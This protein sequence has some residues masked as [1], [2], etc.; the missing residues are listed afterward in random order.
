MKDKGDG[1]LWR[2]ARLRWLNSR[3]GVDSLPVT[4]FTKMKVH[5]KTIVASE[6]TV[7]LDNNGMLQS[8]SLNKKEV[9]EKPVWIEVET[10]NGT[11]TFNKGK[12]QLK[13]MADGLVERT[14]NKR[15]RD[16]STSAASPSIWNTE[17]LC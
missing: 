17:K 11:V 2:M 3:I 15:Q 6:K 13:K 9:L 12:L 10:E 5:G 14:I 7:R 4:P 8:V 16:T 1:D